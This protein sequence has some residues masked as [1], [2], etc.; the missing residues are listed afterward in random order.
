MKKKKKLT[1]SQML[2][3]ITGAL[4]VLTLLEIVVLKLLGVD[5]TDF[6]TQQI[7]TTGGLFGVNIVAYSNKEKMFNVA[8]LKMETI[9]WSWEFK[10]SHKLSSD[11]FQDIQNQVQSIDDATSNKIDSVIS[12]AVN[13]DISIPTI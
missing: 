6:S 9:K 3:I 11:Q 5:T 2:P 13:E 8:R 1:Y 4:F 7:I 12:D 10:E